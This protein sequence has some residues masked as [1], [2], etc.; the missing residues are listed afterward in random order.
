[1]LLNVQSDLLVSYDLISIIWFHLIMQLLRKLHIIVSSNCSIHLNFQ[2]KLRNFQFKLRS[3]IFCIICVWSL[4][5]SVRDYINLHLVPILLENQC[6]LFLCS[7]YLL[8]VLYFEFDVISEDFLTFL[9]L[10]SD[11]FT[12]IIIVISI[13]I[14][15]ICDFVLF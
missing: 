6:F 9:L 14:F 3:Y 15:G 11:K 8:F 4:I 2:F 12:I 5:Y 1:M 10:V 7:Q 13:I